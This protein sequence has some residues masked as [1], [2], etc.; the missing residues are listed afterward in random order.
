[1]DA[2]LTFPSPRD[3]ER[4]CIDHN[5]HEPFRL[6]LK[7]PKIDFQDILTDQLVVR[8]EMSERFKRLIDTPGY[9]FPSKSY[10]AQASSCQTALWKA[11]KLL[12]YLRPKPSIW[13][14]TGGS[15]V[16]SWAFEHLG[17]R[18]IVTE[19][20]PHLALL[21]THNSQVLGSQRAVYQI[22]A[23]DF[24]LDQSFAAIYVDPSRLDHRGQRVY[25]PA[26]SLPNPLTELPKWFGAA[27][28][29][30]IKLSPMVDSAE[31]LRC[32][33][34][35][36]FVWTLSVKREVKELLLLCHAESSSA[37][38]EH[39]AVDLLGNGAER[40][41][42]KIDSACHAPSLSAPKR[43]VYDADA[44]II[45]ARGVPTVAAHFHLE[46]LH[47]EARLLTSDHFYPEFPGRIFE[48]ESIHT[49]FEDAWPDGASVVVRGFPE[50]AEM[51]RKRMR[52]KE[53]AEH[54]LLATCWLDGQRGFLRA[55]RKSA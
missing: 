22:R 28:W 25:H 12:A 14:A 48:L 15:G 2:S 21:H 3:V 20:D 37:A 53:N 17:A 26:D 35:C 49:P 5:G 9:L 8:Q 52:L 41:A 4:F 39:W 19:V 43:Y 7:R 46:Q 6:R 33:P 55:R 31:A 44:S 51:I 45:A 1:M 50:K 13:D 40:Y 34:S 23:E 54:Y 47:P 29:V 42:W 30:M 38:P 16:D 11:D 27:P 24:D 18:L 10:L 32:F 36:R